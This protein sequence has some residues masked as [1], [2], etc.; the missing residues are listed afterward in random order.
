MYF[1]NKMQYII[2]DIYIESESKTNGA[3]KPESSQKDGAKKKSK[4]N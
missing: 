1:I 4:K 2:M 3:K